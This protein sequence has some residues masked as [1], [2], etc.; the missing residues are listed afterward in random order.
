ME[1]QDV[2]DLRIVYHVLI[3]YKLNIL[4]ILTVT[5]ALAF[6]VVTFLPK[7][8]ESSALVRAKVQAGPGLFFTHASDAIALLSGGAS[9]P[10]QTYIE[11]MKSRNVLDAVI[12]Q[13]SLDKDSMD[14]ERLIKDLRFENIRETNLIKITAKGRTPEAA[15]KVVDAVVASFQDLLSNLDQSENSALSVSFQNRM[16][17][18][19]M[20]M[21]KAENELEE[22]SKGTVEY[23]QLERQVQITRAVYEMLVKSYEVQKDMGIGHVDFQI[24]DRPNTQA[25]PSSPNVLAITVMGFVIG[26][27]VSLIYVV[28]MYRKEAR[29]I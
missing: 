22:G 8:Y 5:T 23:T 1:D 18:A 10:T 6:T 3:K 13:L 27:L 12:E 21:E 17:K 16:T 2:I 14:D 11:M 19:K 25:R 7:Q 24:I 4:A 9:N 29:R 20:E 28:L 15:R 26:I